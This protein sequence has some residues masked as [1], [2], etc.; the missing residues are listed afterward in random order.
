MEL[1]SFIDATI[2]KAELTTR[3]VLDIC[4]TA[5]D[6]N[7]AA[8]CIPSRFLSLVVCELEGSKVAPCTVVG[9]P[10]GNMNPKAKIEEAKVAISEGALELDMVLQ[11]GALKAKE[12]QVVQDELASIVSLG[13]VVKAIIE[14]ALLTKEEVV[15]AVEIIEQARAHFVKTSTGFSTRGASLEDIQ[16][17]KA[18][19]KRETKIKASGGIRSREFALELIKA[20]AN[21]IG[22]SHPASLI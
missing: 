11:I 3:E 15:K 8:V 13:G 14:T 20:G 21:R 1:N 7:V 4:K 6:L 12:Y 5:I 10:L 2:L 16:T 17:I 18:A 22:S 9:F 19:I